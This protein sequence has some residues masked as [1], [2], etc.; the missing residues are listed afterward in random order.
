MSLF[1]I[2][3]VWLIAKLLGPG[4]TGPKWPEPKGPTGPTGPTGPGPTGPT[5]PTGGTGPTGPG[6]IVSTDWKPYFYIQPD[7][8][9]TLGTPYALAGEWHGQGKAWTELYNYSQG[10]YISDVPPSS[11]AYPK[12]GY[13]PDGQGVVLTPEYAA[14]GDKLLVPFTWPEPG[15]GTIVSRLKPIPAGTT[16]PAA[17]VTLKRTVLHGDESTETI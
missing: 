6:P 3:L 7:A 11:P 8:G 13:E 15:H 9:A 12:A 2:L 5:G 10:R 16:L 17:A 4:T 14:V 1:D